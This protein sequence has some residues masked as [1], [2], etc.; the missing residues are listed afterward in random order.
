MRAKLSPPGSLTML[1][2][3]TG[4]LAAGPEHLFPLIAHTLTH[5]TLHL[6]TRPVSFLYQLSAES[7]LPRGKILCPPSQVASHCPSLGLHFYDSQ[8]IPFSPHPEQ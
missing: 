3:T 8:V 1:M 4:P 2:H 7:S 5:S 6:P